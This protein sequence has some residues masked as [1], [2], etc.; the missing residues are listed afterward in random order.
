MPPA[1]NLHLNTTDG[2]N[3]PRLVTPKAATTSSSAPGSPQPSPAQGGGTSSP[4][5]KCPRRRRRK[6]QSHSQD[7]TPDKVSKVNLSKPLTSTW[8]RTTSAVSKMDFPPIPTAAFQNPGNN[9]L[10]KK[11]IAAIKC[12]SYEQQLIHSTLEYE[13]ALDLVQSCKM[14]TI[15]STNPFYH[16]DS[17]DHG[18]RTA[19]EFQR[20]THT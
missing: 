5:K 14:G 20:P 4:N 13:H 3:A 9:P 11:G 8:T 17:E 18:L 10:L 6:A 19:R 16:E 2:S 1:A 7:T 15:I 12:S